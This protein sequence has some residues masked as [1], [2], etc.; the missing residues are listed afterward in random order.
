MRLLFATSIVPDGM[1]ASG[2]EIANAAIIDAL[3]RAGADVTVIGFTWPDRS[4]ADPDNTLVVGALDVR[5]QNAGLRTKLVWLAKALKTGL[6]FASAK[7]LVVPDEAIRAR[8]RDAGP[9]DGYILNS[10]QFVAAFEAVLADRP[11]IFVAHNV[12]YRSAEENAAAS[13]GLERWLFRREARLLKI[14][15]ARLCRKA[16]FVFTLAQDDRAPL[17]VADDRKSAVLP[18]VTMRTVPAKTSRAIACDAALIGTWTWQPNRI[19][20]DWFLEKVVPHL[21][22]TFRVRI[23]GN[24]PQGMSSSHP[25]VE[26]VG[27]VPDARAFVRSGAVVPLIS[28]AGSGVQLKTIETFELGLPSVATSRSLRGIGYRPVNCVVTD[29]PVA[30][31]NGLA[32]AAKAPRDADGAAFHASQLKALDA[33]VARGLATLTARRQEVGA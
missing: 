12:E 19:G 18:L 3:R 31:A 10:V 30:F 32:A 16:H 24:I 8:I 2:Y 4:P 21:P 23:A 1:L 28:T 26:F 14:L 29:D 15:E 17:G 33:A 20:L 22:G 25:G 5:T 27:R 6:T 9:F 13:S 7:L 11:S